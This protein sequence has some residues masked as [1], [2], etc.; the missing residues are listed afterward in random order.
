MNLE[1]EVDKDGR[2]GKEDKVTLVITAT[3]V[4]T[5]NGAH[6]VQEAPRV[7][8]AQRAPG[9][10]P[11]VT[12]NGEEQVPMDRRVKRETQ[13][14]QGCRANQD[15]LVDKENE[16]NKDLLD[17]EDLRARQVL[18][19][20]QVRQESTDQWG[21]QAKEELMVLMVYRESAVNPANRVFQAP[22][23]KMAIPE[24]GGRRDLME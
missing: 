14:I 24:S 5:A 18:Q 16:V 17:R 13:A 15:E 12:G 4:P 21:Y 2:D 22:R 23:E 6:Q 11:D 8:A 1:K 7:G 3:Q 10:H 9:A 19:V 20:R